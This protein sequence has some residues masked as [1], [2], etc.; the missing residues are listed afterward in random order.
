MM[1]AAALLAGATFA[2]PAAAQTITPL[3]EARLR[4]EGA[5]QAGIAGRADAV[6]LRVRTGLQV[7]DGPWSALAEAQGNLAVVGDYFDGVNGAATRPLVADP[8]NI[9]L[10]RAQLQYRT[11]TMAITAGRQRIV[12]D[13]ERFVGNI[14]FRQNAQTFDAVRA[15]LAPTKGLKGDFSYVRS[16]RTLWGM[17]GTGARPQAVPGD[18]ILANLGWASPIGTLTGF[19]YWIDQDEAAVQGYR[20]SSRT[21]GARLAGA[22]PIGKASLAYQ[23][24]YAR[25][26]DHARNPN[27]YAADYYLADVTLNLNGP[28]LGL[29][30]E[31]L[32]AADGAAL[33]SFQTPLAANFR[34]NGWAEK[35]TIKP[36]DG[37]RDQYASAGWGWPAIGAL[38]NVSVQA[39]Y[40]RFHSDRLVRPYGDEIDL[41]ATARLGRTTASV[42]YADYDAQGFATDTRKL[43]LQLDWTI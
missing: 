26:S 6:T 18:T 43:W 2:A 36:A 29:G 35:F 13:D 3:A 22:Q 14:P 31:V 7:T 17:D 38:K 39:I 34:F 25:Q 33:T 21:F 20:L 24:S 11:Q 1:R 5:E 16:V 9:A 23:A 12:L 15:E 10:Y 32:G 42:R 41:L 28:K 8:Q 4:Y 30:Y 40:H 27:D 37:L 19:G